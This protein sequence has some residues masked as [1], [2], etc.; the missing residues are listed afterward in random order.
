MTRLLVALLCTLMLATA[1]AGEVERVRP[2][3]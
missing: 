3:V 2:A 1:V